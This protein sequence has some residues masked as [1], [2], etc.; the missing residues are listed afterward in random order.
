MSI[1]KRSIAN[2]LFVLNGGRDAYL[3]FLRNLTPQVMLMTIG[4]IMWTKIR[5]DW[6][7][8]FATLVF[9]GFALLAFWVNAKEFHRQ[10][11]IP[12]VAWRTTLER[13][14]TAKNIH[15]F[16]CRVA[17]KSKI[18]WRS[19]FVEFV[20]QILVIH[21]FLFTLVAVMAMS[22]FSAMGVLLSIRHAG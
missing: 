16:R 20:E 17:A 5:L 4:F 1:R 14:L 12:W 6:R 3:N 7:A 2:R 10:F 13:R 21:L 22:G 8:V 19:R 15:G 18:I 9:T 11:S